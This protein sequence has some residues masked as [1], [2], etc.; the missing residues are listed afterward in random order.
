MAATALN[1]WMTDY[2]N[3]QSS[4]Q[5]Q[6][7][8]RSTWSPQLQQLEANT[9][10]LVTALRKDPYTNVLLNAA[11]NATTPEAQ[12]KAIKSPRFN[13]LQ[14]DCKYIATDIESHLGKPTFEFS[15]E[16]L[17]RLRSTIISLGE[18]IKKSYVI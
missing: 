13:Q 8:M 15:R 1:N 17:L 12:L 3:L 14:E 18:E 9:L 5:V 4:P 10:N 2:K 11:E 6:Q 7:A 16:D